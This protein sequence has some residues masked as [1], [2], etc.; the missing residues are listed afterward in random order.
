MYQKIIKRFLDILLSVIS[1]IVL[2]PLF[3]ILSICVLINMGSPIFFSQRRIGMNEKAFSLYKFRS[4]TNKK[5]NNGNLLPEKERLTKFGIKLRS[6]SLDELPELFSILKGDMS[7]VGPRP[8]P[9]YYGPYFLEQERIRHNVRGGLIPP[10]SLCGEPT[11]DWE[12]QF[13]YET[14]YANNCSFI[15]DIKIILYTFLILV[16]RVKSNYGADDRPHLNIYRASM[17]ISQQIIDEWNNR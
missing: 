12:T 16:K 10:D 5:D 2:S 8:L 17:V 13:Q 15:L 1:I 4:M 3:I 11:C 7:F 6:S 14:Y 9:T